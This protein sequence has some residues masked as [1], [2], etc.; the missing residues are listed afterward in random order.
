MIE[1]IEFF[2]VVFSEILGK[3]RVTL[4]P[5]I[6]IVSLSVRLANRK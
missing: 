1:L 5:Y 6:V 3:Q 4:L 2:L